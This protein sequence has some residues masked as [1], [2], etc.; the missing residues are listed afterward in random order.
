M[1]EMT[2]VEIMNLLVQRGYTKHNAALVTP[3]LQQLHPDL[4]P[5]WEQWLLHPEACDDY[6]VEGFS[7]KGLM[8][9]QRM[10]YP[11][12]LLTL[13]WLLKDPENAKASLNRRSSLP[14]PTPRG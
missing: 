8:E 12:A 14:T 11:A 3:E 7:L 6:T 10:A 9:Q 13:D 4:K 2:T 5:L 1:L